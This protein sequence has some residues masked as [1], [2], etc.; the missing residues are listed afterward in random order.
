MPTALHSLI[1]Y[2]EK[3]DLTFPKLQDVCLAGASITPHNLRQVVNTL[4]ARAVSTGFGMTEGSPIWVAATADP[5]TLIAGDDTIS[6][7]ASPGARIK[8]CASNS[9]LPLPRGQPGEIHESGPGVIQGYLG[10]NVGTESFYVDEGRSWFMTGDRAIMH[11]DGRVS[12]IGRCKDMIIRGGENIAPAAIEAVLNQFPG[13]EAQ[14]VA[15]KDKFAGEV[16]VAIVRILPAGDDPCGL[17]SDAVRTSMGMLHV[18]DEIVM[19]DALS[20]NEYPRTMSGKIQKSALRKVVAAFRKHRTSGEPNAGPQ[21]FSADKVRS[22]EETVLHVW[23][24]ATGIAP[25]AL[26]K[27]APTSNFADSITTM[28]VR[29]MYRKELGLTLSAHEMIEHPNLQSQILA[30]Q[31]KSGHRQAGDSQLS[32]VAAPLGLED[33][34]RVVGP[35]NDANSFKETASLALK[36]YGF[37]FENDVGEIIQA[38]DFTNVLLRS[39]I[40]DSWNFGIAIVAEGSTTASLRKALVA[41]LKQSSLWTSFYVLGEDGSPFYVTMKPQEKLYEQCLTVCGSVPTLADLQQKAI[42]YPHP[43]HATYPGLL[44]HA[45]VYHVE[46]LNSAA[47]VMY[48]H[49]ALHDASS[50]R[51][52][53][54]DLN[55]SLRAPHQQLRPH[56][57]FKTWAD[58]YHSLRDSPRATMEV[59]WHVKRLS[60]LHLHR[61]ALHPPARVPRQATTANPDGIDYGF[62]APNLLN[63]KKHH[64][65]ITASVVLKVAMTLVNITR[66]QHTHALFSNFEA[67]RASLPFWPETLRHLPTSDGTTLADLDASDVA[68]PTMNAVT[69][70]IQVHRSESALDFLTRLQTEQAELTKRA[71]APWRRIMA[72]LDALHPSENAGAMISETHQTQFLT[73]VPGFLGDY[74]KI[75]VVQIAIR[76]ALGL[77]FVAGLG[78]PQA[79]TFMISLRWDVANYSQEETERFVGDVEKAV[80]WLLEEGNWGS[81]VAEFLDSITNGPQGAGCGTT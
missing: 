31:R 45:L 56:V 41:A 81:S 22:V 77:C 61:Q 40:M 65:H 68:G 2:A 17:M 21:S 33:I 49:H 6:G 73:W 69:N 15:A 36:A 38:S 54:E 75:R 4:G 12:I 14:V 34:Q 5:E 63:L 60:D 16:P 50:M 25:T 24:R 13:V 80:V 66:T 51:L 67:A 47:F 71:H 1:E 48:L 57:P 29:D 64:P 42:R 18:P 10:D 23:W 11:G 39:K 53:L 70:L 59:N 7:S 74:E 20:L 52:V 55:Q 62:D 78:G 3:D 8:I 30:L 43:E 44:F 76:A 35:E 9:I 58:I 37:D 32:A 26:D 46:E 19:L 72:K 27:E 28:R 79:T